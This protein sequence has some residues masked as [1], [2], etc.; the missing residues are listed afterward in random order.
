M[1]DA[2]GWASVPTMLVLVMVFS[3]T[4]PLTGCGKTPCQIRHRFDFL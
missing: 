1:T 4:S 3:L 2:L